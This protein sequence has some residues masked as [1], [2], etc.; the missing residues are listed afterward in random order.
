M[1]VKK[2]VPC[3]VYDIP[4]MQEWLD[5]MALQGLFLV[6]FSPYSD[7]AVFRQGEPKPVRYRLD[8]IRKDKTAD[9]DEPYAEMGWEFVCQLSRHFYVYS[10]GDPEAPELYTDSQSLA[11]ALDSLMKRE[12]RNTILIALFILSFGILLLFATRRQFLREL[13]LWESPRFLATDIAFL[14][15]MVVLLP[16]LAVETKRILNIRN[17][18]AQGLPLKAKRRW[19]RPLFW[20]WYIPLILAINL[21]PRFFFPEIGWEVGELNAMALS[22]T[23]PTIIQT[24][25]LGPRPLEMEPYPDGYATENSSWLAPVQEERST[26]WYVRFP[27]DTVSHSYTYWTSVR[28]VQASSPKVAELIYQVELA[29]A[30]KTLKNWTEWTGSATHITEY[31]GFTPW[32]WSGVDRME[33]ARYQQRDLDAWTFAAL[34]GTDILVVKY[35]GF[36]QPEDCA[37][38]FL[39]AL[40]GEEAN[41]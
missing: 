23:W 13:L 25:A 5:E 30:E 31:T 21:F 28:Y 33:V 14:I 12:V 10:C 37:G 41:S 20:T 8:P 24:E 39:A 35:R 38:L 3:S 1:T 11:I 2:P 18:L 32:E 26:T 15:L 40:D 22:H 36:A 34:R 6:E 17:T 27:N 7:R 9:R 4:G 16:L 19:N 29:D